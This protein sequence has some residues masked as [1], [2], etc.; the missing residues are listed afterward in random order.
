MRKCVYALCVSVLSSL[1]SLGQPA[2]S[3]TFAGL[4]SPTP[5]SVIRRGP[6]EK[7]WERL[8]YEY[9]PSG[10]VISRPHRYTE[11]ATGL[12]FWSGVSNQWV[13]TV[14]QI[15]PLSDGSAAAATNGPHKV[16]FP[17][18]IYSGAVQLVTPDGLTIQS[19]P[20]G[21]A[22]ADESNSVMIASLTN[23]IGQ[24]LPSGNQI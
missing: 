1:S 6:N 20:I 24:L 11:I 22:Y 3:S 7:V 12:E 8:E 18:D 17:A 4:P 14:E 19:R 9:S 13:D 5:Y 16:F 21:I 15:L 10:N 23:S 2:S